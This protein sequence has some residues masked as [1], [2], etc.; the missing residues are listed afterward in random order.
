MSLTILI[1]ILFT[2]LFILAFKM[3]KAV[4]TLVG[5]LLFVVGLAFLLRSLEIINFTIPN[6]LSISEFNFEISPT[7]K[8][9]IKDNIKFKSKEES[10]TEKE[11]QVEEENDRIKE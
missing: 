9:E 7:I 1:V 11:S 2:L 4:L 6:D 10:V 8:D 3:L 5:G